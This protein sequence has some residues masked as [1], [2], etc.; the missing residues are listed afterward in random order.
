MHGQVA[1]LHLL[2]LSQQNNLA[3]AGAFVTIHVIVS[4]DYNLIPLQ[5]RELPMLPGDSLTYLTG[6][7]NLGIRVNFK[8]RERFL[9]EPERT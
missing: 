2:V 8:W 4:T 6:G 3:Q 1:P 7:V 9:E 5:I